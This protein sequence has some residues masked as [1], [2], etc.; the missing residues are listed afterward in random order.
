MAVQGRPTPEASAFQPSYTPP[1]WPEAAAARRGAV[2]VIDD[3]ECVREVMCTMLGIL[4]FE[5]L[6]ASTGAE[7]LA[8]VRRRPHEVTAV[9]LDLTM[10]GVSGVETLHLLRAVRRDLPIILMSGFEPVAD[11][12]ILD[13]PLGFLRKPFRLRDLSGALRAV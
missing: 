10:P 13:A 2:L 5:A 7:G 6:D 9:L 4:G 12:P 3:E 11:L 8:L 1:S